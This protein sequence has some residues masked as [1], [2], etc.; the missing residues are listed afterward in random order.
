ME[1]T[2]IYALRKVKVTSYNE[3]LAFI[4]ELGLDIDLLIAN[5]TINSELNLK[6]R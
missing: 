4:K 3:R 2:L 6:E 5:G 1:N